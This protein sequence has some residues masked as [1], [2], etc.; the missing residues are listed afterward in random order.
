MRVLV[1]LM[2][3]IFFIFGDEM[4]VN[5]WNICTIHSTSVF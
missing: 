4:C 2:N 5:S 1:K 3:V